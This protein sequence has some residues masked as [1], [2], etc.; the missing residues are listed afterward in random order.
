M[1]DP[2]TQRPRWRPSTRGHRNNM[3]IFLPDVAV[4]RW[5]RSRGSCGDA[6]DRA[7]VHLCENVAVQLDLRVEPLWGKVESDAVVFNFVEI[8]KL[9][10]YDVDKSCI[11]G[12]LGDKVSALTVD[13]N[14]DA[15]HGRQRFNDGA[16]CL[17][18]E[19]GSGRFRCL[20]ELLRR[21]RAGALL[22]V[23]ACCRWADNF[24]QETLPKMRQTLS[25]TCVLADREG[26]DG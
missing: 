18:V 6:K 11:V 7:I 26:Q 3:I 9:G 13:E 4:T 15:R 8:T 12:R 2:Q 17:V 22:S 21:S 23:S 20:V 5:S 1:D 24:R 14:D 10:T 19:R 25:T 16:G